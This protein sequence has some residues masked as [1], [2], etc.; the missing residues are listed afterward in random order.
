MVLDAVLGPLTQGSIP[1]ARLQLAREA[2]LPDVQKPD[3]LPAKELLTNHRRI[4]LVPA[5]FAVDGPRAKAAPRYHVLIAEQLRNDGYDVVVDK[6]ID[7]AW[8]AERNAA[9]GFYDPQT[10]A[11]DEVR[12]RS[13]AGGSSLI[14][15][16]ATTSMPS[17]SPSSSRSS[18]PLPEAWPS[19]MAPKHSR[20][21]WPARASANT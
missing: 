9:G 20:L 2:P 14:S 15:E 13:R 18:L 4:G 6:D 5:Q 19:G 8:D 21:S 11:F 1:P 16:G 3:C 7:G 10:G 17:S 12:W